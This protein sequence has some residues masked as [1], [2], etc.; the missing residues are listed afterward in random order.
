VLGSQMAL[1]AIRAIVG[2]FGDGDDGLVGRLLMIDARDALRDAALRLG[3]GQPA[4]REPG[5]R[6]GVRG[7]GG[8]ENVDFSPPSR[9]ETVRPKSIRGMAAHLFALAKPTQLR[10]PESRHC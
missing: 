2:G 10:S 4:K 7:A 5:L 1:E 8:P 6:Q 9:V 3:R